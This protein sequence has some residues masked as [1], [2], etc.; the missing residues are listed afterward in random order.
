M[1][2]IKK[3]SLANRVRIKEVAKEARC[4]PSYLYQI[5]N[6]YRRPSATL[7]LRIEEATGG[8]VTLR[9]LFPKDAK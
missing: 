8:A 6:G 1:N 4:S 2:P 9:D 7:A 3:F 5:I